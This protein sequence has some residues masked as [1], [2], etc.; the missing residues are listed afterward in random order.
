[1]IH[2]VPGTIELTASVLELAGYDRG[3]LIEHLPIVDLRTG[4]MRIQLDKYNR[5]QELFYGHTIGIK[6]IPKNMVID[7]SDTYRDMYR[8]VPPFFATE[9]WRNY[10]ELGPTIN[11]ERHPIRLVGV[12]MYV[13]QVRMMRE[14]SR[15]GPVACL[16]ILRRWAERWLRR[17]PLLGSIGRVHA[18]FQHELKSGKVYLWVTWN[19]VDVPN[20]DTSDLDNPL[21]REVRVPVMVNLRTL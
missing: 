9:Y 11:Y 21:R 17:Q 19:Y 16:P 13:K 15:P 20:I 10:P 3:Y 14:I 12:V 7:A 1:M 8:N 2:G 5:S 18:R 4:G 6:I